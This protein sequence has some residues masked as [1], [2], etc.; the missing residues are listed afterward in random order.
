[1]AVN[2][3]GATSDLLEKLEKHS[4]AISGTQHG[5]V[6]WSCLWAFPAPPGG[7]TTRL[8]LLMEL[9]DM[10]EEGIDVQEAC[11]AGL[12]DREDLVDEQSEL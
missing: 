8:P 9:P 11:D 3:V 1:M 2:P 10:A 4:S 5:P 6:T 12:V 7:K